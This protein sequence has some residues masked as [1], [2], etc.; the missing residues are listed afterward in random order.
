MKRKLFTFFALIC[1]YGVNYAF[2]AESEPN[3]DRNSANVLALNGSNTGAIDPAGD[4][5]WWQLTT[6]DNGKVEVSLALLPG[7]KYLWIELY[8]NDG[9]TLLSSDY[10]NKDFTLSYD[11]LA[12]GTFYI[13]IKAYYS[14][15]TG[16]YTISNQLI[17]P[18]EANDPEPNNK[19]EDAKPITL[20]STVTGHIGYYYNLSRDTLD[21][22]KITIADDGLL[23][24]TLTSANSRYVNVYLYDNNG[25]TELANGYTNSSFTLNKDGLAAGTY[26]IKI[27]AF[28]QYDFA[29]YSLSSE[30]V[31]PAQ[32]NDNEPN[33]KYEQAQTL[34]LGDSTTGHIGYYYNNRR[35]TADWYVINVPENG[36]LRLNATP[37]NGTYIYVDLYDNNGTTQLAADYSNKRF[38]VSKDGLA[39]GTY[40]VKVRTFYSYEFAPYN[41]TSELVQPDEP[42]DTEP[43]NNRENAL[44]LAVNATVTGHVGYYY[45]LY[46]DTADW[47]KL[48]IPD[49]GMI[50]LTCTPTNGTYIYV[51]LYDNDGVTTLKADNSNKAFK[52]SQDGLAKGTYY[53]KVRTFYSY[54]FAPYILTD[55]L[56]LYNAAG[57]YVD[58]DLPYK[59]LTLPPNKS[60]SGHVG[61]Y[62]DKKSDPVDWWKINYT[63]TG[64]LTVDLNFERNIGSGGYP[65]T[66]LSIYSDTTKSPIFSQYTN[67][68]TVT[69]NFTAMAKGTLWVKIN[70]YYSYEFSAYTLMPSFVV[71]DTARITLIAANSGD[72]NNGEL[73]FDIRGGETPY[74]V[75]LYRFGSTYGGMINVEDSGTF[76]VNNLPPGKYT[77]TAMSVSADEGAFTTSGEGELL[78]PSA[79]GLVATGITTKTADLSWDAVGCA[80]GYVVAYRVKGTQGWKKRKV[81]APNTG[82]TLKQLEA[83][84]VYQWV[85]LAGSGDPEDD[86]VLSEYAASI[87]KTKGS[88]VA[89][90]ENQ[91]L[92]TDALKTE[93]TVYPN[94]AVSQINVK[95]STNENNLSITLKD[96][97]GKTVWQLQNV[98]AA[99]VAATTINLS[100]FKG[101]IY[102]L[103]VS[104][105]SGMIKTEKIII[106]R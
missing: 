49:D 22:Y 93:I 104:G 43:N 87:F 69:A 74:S 60:T 72:C 98:S 75:Q 67:N 40:Y 90:E 80:D 97:V 62:F 51:Y 34:I 7:S 92:K 46:R 19:Y 82:I 65:Y 5:D 70:C 21:W 94:P 71:P 32:T 3:N 59:A 39:K 4:V 103:T 26:Y 2:A 15:D 76:V 25:I 18:T 99:K 85:V 53:V 30:L 12:A 6:T 47:Y 24:L 41:L 78:T 11:G 29:P 42:E 27:R 102:F 68:G 61:F 44:D 9:I 77:A 55:S 50:E 81:E 48:T 79:T 52:I 10:S 95:I 33:D 96:I 54:D 63:G 28:Y 83:S 100:N 17:L 106:S 89:A 31:T 14:Y 91:N 37:V 101:G 64:D 35:D 105:P 56:K 20:G 66:Y 16:S 58:N 8:D 45:N 13:K 36:L 23:K 88:N 73:Q 84:T 57:D 38:T 1:L 86:Y